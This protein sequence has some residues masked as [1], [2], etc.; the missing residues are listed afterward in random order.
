MLAQRQEVV[1]SMSPGIDRRQRMLYL[2][3]ILLPCLVI[4]ALGLLLMSRERELAG[5]RQREEER[6]RLRNFGQELV[7]RLERLKL[8]QMTALAG[9]DDALCKEQFV[10]PAFALVTAIDGDRLVLPWD[11]DP[12]PAAARKSLG[13]SGFAGRIAAGER[14][15]LRDGNP[16]KAAEAYRQILQAARDPVQAAYSR[17]LLARALAAAGRTAEARVCAEALLALPPGTVD[18]QG[19]PFRLYAASRLLD[20]AGARKPADPGDGARPDTRRAHRQSTRRA[21]GG[22]EL[23][24]PREHF[25]NSP[26]AGG[27]AMSRILVI[28]DDP[29]IARGLAHNL[30]CEGHEVVTAADGETG[31][32][33]IGEKKPD[34]II[35]DLML[36]KLGGYEI[37][38]KARAAGI[39]MPILMLTARGEEADRV[40]GLDL[41]ADDYVAKPFSVRELMARVRALLRRA[42]PARALPNEMRFDDVEVD[43]LRYEARR[44]G[45]PVDLTRKEFA[46]LRVLAAR[47]GEVV[48]RDALLDEVWGYENYPTT[49]T[50]DSHILNLRAKLEREPANPR[51]LVTVHGVGY[52]W[53]GGTT[54]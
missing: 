47:A 21:C 4:V 20:T 27:Q 15:E 41:G 46:V 2:V 25:C 9:R 36:P 45:K 52:K 33:W 13:E 34:L 10:D 18:D 3:A 43:F 17:L 29:A 49:R 7:V 24:R 23:T 12:A 8:R 39:G 51:H 11:A 1:S 26:S 53:I 22:R 42:H 28:E 38:R 16:Q 48:T 14:M 50:V 19:I 44:A 40:L 6:S 37:C 35:L 54:C 31:Y 5:N 32:Q 30:K